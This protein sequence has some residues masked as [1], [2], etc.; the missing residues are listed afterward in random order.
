M[1]AVAI[2]LVCAFQC[3]PVR[4]AWKPI[5]SGTCIDTRKF[6][7]TGSAIDLATWV[8]LLLLPM[9]AVWKLQKKLVDRISLMVI[10]TLGGL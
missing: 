6:F 7:L 4:V 5:D 9:P 10:F 1:L 8:V 2:A 3:T